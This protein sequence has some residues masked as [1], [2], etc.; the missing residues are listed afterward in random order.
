MNSRDFCSLIPRPSTLQFLITCSIC[1]LQ[2][3]KNWSVEGLGTR[4]SV[5][6]HCSHQFYPIF[7]ADGDLEMRPAMLCVLYPHCYHAM[8]KD[9][10][11]FFAVCIQ[12]LKHCK[13][14]VAIQYKT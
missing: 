8:N 14:R 7:H 11:V 4:L 12:H 6:P 3:I 9:R 10:P 2:M 1:I 13:D 5:V